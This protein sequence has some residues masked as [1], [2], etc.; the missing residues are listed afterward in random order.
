MATARPLLS[1]RW[2]WS[3]RRFSSLSTIPLR[4][5]ISTYSPAI[6][7]REVEPETAGYCR[8]FYFFSDQIELGS[9]LSE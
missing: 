7:L 9:G 6:I 8:T 2:R 1:G 3:R 4:S 5:A